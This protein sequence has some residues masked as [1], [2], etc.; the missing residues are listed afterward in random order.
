[1]NSCA[2]R[3]HLS[4]G[5]QVLQALSFYANMAAAFWPRGDCSSL[6]A[7]TAD[8]TSNVLSLSSTAESCKCHHR[9][10]HHH[11]QWQRWPLPF[12]P[13][14]FRVNEVA[15]DAQNRRF[16]CGLS[17][18]MSPCRS[19][20]VFKMLDR[21]G[22]RSSHSM[23]SWHLRSQYLSQGYSCLHPQCSLSPT[24]SVVAQC[25]IESVCLRNGRCF[26]CFFF[27]PK[28]NSCRLCTSISPIVLS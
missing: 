18:G 9:F 17:K 22:K 21:P 23:G 24:R 10:C 6:T 28:R 19:V 15:A 4:L 12:F 11:H 3:A 20:H 27:F 16:I 8:F 1:M 2:R 14:L 25:L 13:L 26:C 7:L 5:C